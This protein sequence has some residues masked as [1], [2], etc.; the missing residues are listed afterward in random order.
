MPPM[1]TTAS[2]V[3]WKLESKRLRGLKAS[4]QSA[5]KPMVFRTLRSR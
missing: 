1:E 3:I 2:S 4:R 5:A